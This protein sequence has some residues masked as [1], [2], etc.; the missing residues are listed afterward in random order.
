MDLWYSNKTN[1]IYGE[2]LNKWI[3]L[4]S[5]AIKIAVIYARLIIII[6]VVSNI[7]YIEK[8]FRLILRL[9]YYVARILIRVTNLK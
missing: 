5:P 2:N 3:R 7:V 1:I 4:F 8:R 9:Y 6:E